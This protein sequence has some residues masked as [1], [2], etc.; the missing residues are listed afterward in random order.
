MSSPHKQGP[1]SRDPVGNI[2]GSS[3]HLHR[4]IWGRVFGVKYSIISG[5]FFS[6]NAALKSDSK[7]NPF[8]HMLPGCKQSSH[9]PEFPEWEFHRHHALARF[10]WPN[11]LRC[12][13]EDWRRRNGE[14][15]SCNQG[16]RSTGTTALCNGPNFYLTYS[17]VCYVLLDFCLAFIF[18][19]CIILRLGFFIFAN[20]VSYLRNT[21]EVLA[22]VSLHNDGFSWWGRGQ[23]PPRL[24]PQE[25]SRILECFCILTSSSIRAAELLR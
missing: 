20:P 9:I 25:E 2:N 15:Q 13:H 16:V 3:S 23:R 10:N 19:K 18:P 6:S 1:E 17:T 7:P 21:C 11:H 5:V 22:L 8:S 12:V 14:D 4:H 24:R